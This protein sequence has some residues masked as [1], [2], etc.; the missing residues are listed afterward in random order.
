MAFAGNIERSFEFSQVL[1]GGVIFVAQSADQL[2]SG[3]SPH[4]YVK[5][6]DKKLHFVDV[7]GTDVI[8]ESSA[9][10]QILTLPTIKDG[11]LASGSVSN[12]FSASTGT[13]KT[14]S[15]ANQ[16]SGDVTI[17]AGKNLSTAAGAGV[18]DLS[19][20][21]G[22]MK[23]PTSASSLFTFNQKQAASATAN[24]IADPGGAN[25]AIPVT[26]S[27]T[28]ALTIASA[29]A[30]T[31]TLAIPT[32]IGQ[33]LTIVADTVGTGTRAITAAS[34]V[35]GAGNTVMTFN[36]VRDQIDLIGITVAGTRA[37]A[38]LLNISVTLS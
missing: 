23:T 5:T 3:S 30:E 9:S 16:L 20:A 19:L 34:A 22:A 21:T 38:I 6:S 7:D 17:A 2:P 8:F 29:G 32:F 10:G 26:A 25:A 28:V 18:I 36:A 37:W 27:G 31:N 24:A 11:L 12:D 33:R 4:L 35:N 15:G 1:L 13:F 14:S